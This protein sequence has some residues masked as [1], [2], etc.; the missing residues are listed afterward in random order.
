MGDSLFTNCLFRLFII[1][2][3]DRPTHG[4]STYY[5]ASRLIIEGEEIS[6]FYDDEWFSSKVKAFTPQVY[7]IYHVNLQ[8]ASLIVLPLAAFD[9]SIARIIWTIF[10]FIILVATVGFLISKFNYRKMWLPL[11]LILLLTY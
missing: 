10:N 2:I 11:I 7:E 4:F 1:S 3:S 9:Y 6:Q 5:T 8:T